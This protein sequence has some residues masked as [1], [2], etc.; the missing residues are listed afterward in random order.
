MIH[1]YTFPKAYINTPVNRIL[2]MANGIKIFQPKFINWSY[3]NLGIVQR[4]HIKK[5]I[6]NN[7]FVK[8]HKN[9]KMAN[10]F[11]SIYCAI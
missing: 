9:C 11:P 6:P 4:I 3:L 5:K 7:T 8:K 1:S 2:N 10:R